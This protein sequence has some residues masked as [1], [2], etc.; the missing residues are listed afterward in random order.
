MKKVVAFFKKNWMLAVVIVV[1]LVI[2]YMYKKHGHVE[3]FGENRCMGCS[4]CDQGADLGEIIDKEYD[5][6]LDNEYSEAA[7]QDEFYEDDEESATLVN[8]DVVQDVVGLDELIKGLDDESMNTCDREETV[9]IKS[10]ETAPTTAVETPA[11][12]TNTVG[13]ETPV[14][15]E[16]SGFDSEDVFECSPAEL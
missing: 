5:D 7:D 9:P 11:V 1:S 12:T 6:F 13:Q 15:E 4:S 8:N 2:L 3:K 14:V 16:V 10:I